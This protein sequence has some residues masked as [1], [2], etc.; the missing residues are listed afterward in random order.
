MN[1]R[2]SVLDLVPIVEGSNVKE[3]LHNSI[4]LAKHV[5]SLGFYRYWVAEHHSMP[6][7][8]S[9]ATALVMSYIAQ[10]TKSIRVGAGGIMLPNHAPLIIA[11]QFG[12]LES[13]HQGRI[14]LGLGRAP[15]TNP[16]TMLA[17]RGDTTKT[18]DDFPEKLQELRNFFLPSTDNKSVMSIPGEGCNIPIWLLGSSDFSARLAARLGLPFSFASHFTPE[19]TMAAINYYR[20]TFVPSSDL[21]R[22][23]YMVALNVFAADTNKVAYKISTSSQQ[24]FLSLI[25]NKPSKMPPPVDDM[26][27]L[28]SNH[29]KLA[30]LSRL[31]STV[32]GTKEE[33]KKGINEFV[34]KTGANEI[35]IVCSTYDINDR[36]RSYEIIAEAVM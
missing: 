34:S 19:N 10:A 18:G 8:G 25:R 33:V 36:K 4:N 5:E 24:Q 7:I 9:A 2:Y 22:P 13:M 1:I 27:V 20:S 11:E 17:I 12:T 21:S 26:D 30:V 23:Y 32:I 31:D 35:I 16:Q 15:G 6:G 29:E 3:A 28:W 14:D